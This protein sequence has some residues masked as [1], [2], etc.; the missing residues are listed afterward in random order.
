M[1]SVMELPTTALC[2]LCFQRCE[3]GVVPPQAERAGVATSQVSKL[4]AQQHLLAGCIAGAAATAVTYP[5]EL[6]RTH[7]AMGSSNYGTVYK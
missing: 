1:L 5:F 6:L 3:Q 4:T 7:M 2:M